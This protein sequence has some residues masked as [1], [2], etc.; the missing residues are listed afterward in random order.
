MKEKDLSSDAYLDPNFDYKKLT[1]TEL[2]KILFENNVNVRS[3]AL[4][5][6]L[7]NYYK[8]YIY[9]K[10]E[11]LKEKKM[12]EI[13]K[14]SNIYQSGSSIVDINFNDQSTTEKVVRRNSLSGRSITGKNSY[15]EENE[16]ISLNEKL[17][18][19]KNTPSRN[20]S[21]INKEQT[22]KKENEETIRS[23]QP[24][25]SNVDKKY[26]PLKSSGVK[27]AKNEKKS[28]EISPDTKKIVEKSSDTKK[29]V[30][31][32]PG[33]KKIVEES[34]DTKKIVEKS[35]DIKKFVEK[36]PD[37]KKILEESTPK[38]INYS[39]ENASFRQVISSSRNNISKADNISKINL[40]KDKI[41]TNLPSKSKNEKTINDTTKNLSFSRAINKDTSF[42]SNKEQLKKLIEE[43]MKKHPE[44]KLSD[45]SSFVNSSF[46]NY[47]GTSFPSEVSLT[48]PD[49]KKS[50]YK[51]I[52]IFLC[53]LILALFLLAKNLPY[54]DGK[55]FFCVRVPEHG[56][57]VNKKLVCD[58][59]YVVK[60]SIFGI[61][62]AKDNYKKR[63]FLE[64]LNLLAF[65]KGDYIYG[66]VK[67]PSI[68]IKDLT[69]NESIIREIKN[70]PLLICEGD[71]V[72][73]KNY[74][75][76]VRTFL[77]FYAKRTISICLPIT[78]CLCLIKYLLYKRRKRREVELLSKK[79]TKDV[80]NVLLR[81]LIISTSNTRF[82][83]YVF[84][85]QLKDVFGEDSAVWQNVIKNVSKNANVST[86][87]MKDKD[88][89]QWIGP[90]V[91]RKE[92][93]EAM[94]L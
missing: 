57:I 73:S 60:W 15:I 10:L 55:C 28:D 47:T 20:N 43:D 85:D 46:T 77:H 72:S 35:P 38:N 65:R 8:L 18:R 71:Q 78:L 30:E 54:E 36:S 42:V 69:E 87:K 61:Y 59:G 29:I 75:V 92:S 7:L 27:S 62:C 67:N 25:F 31:K 53:A 50:K 11:D 89:W 4:K 94:K 64:I 56:N 16:P 84:I 41:K 12:K 81:Q 26:S 52:L 32:S 37:T 3:N 93:I 49:I 33:T 22:E 5:Q 40:E 13:K 14:M 6:E 2:K 19:I 21:F 66:R 58:K 74:K 51:R 17:E 70:H 88:A 24:F 45:S 79:V 80:L 83:E 68:N 34:L 91:R 48:V 1:K 82:P 63:L 76:S 44:R 23:E 90:I 39:S 9:D 86:L